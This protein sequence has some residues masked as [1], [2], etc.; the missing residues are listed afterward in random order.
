MARE[1]AVVGAGVAGASVVC[2]LRDV[3]AEITVFEER[4]V[5]GGRAA[6]ARRNRCTFDYGANYVK[7]GDDRVDRLVTQTIDRKGLI[8]VTESVWTFDAGGTI[9]E[10]DDRDDHK[11]SYESGLSELAKRLFDQGTATIHCETGITH[12]ERV[13]AADSTD[14]H[15]S[16]GR[17]RLHDSDA[18]ARGPFD[19]VVLTP[20]APVAAAIL[21]ASGWDEPVRAELVSAAQKVPYRP[22]Y[23]A[24]LH[25]PFEVD[26][27]WYALVNTDNEHAIGWLSR[28][29]CKPG[30]VP[31]GESLFIVQMAPDWSR[32]RFDDPPGEVCADAAALTANLLSDRRVEAPDWTHAEVW[33]NAL[34]DDRIDPDLRHRAEAFG[35]YC[36]GDWIAGEGRIHR[37]MRTGLTVGDRLRNK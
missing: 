2:A 26:R 17:W 23:S 3:D 15:R 22:I 9:T 5:L 31:D 6:T 4:S 24:V 12:L 21:E 36:A 18:R 8:D 27:D 14:P 7:S 1:I 32:E 11:W 34:A 33:Q 35:L 20:P 10:G 25:Y 29:S 28:E 30:H 13:E 19:E 16:S 37:A